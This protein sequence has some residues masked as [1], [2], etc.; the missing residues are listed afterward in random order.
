MVLLCNGLGAQVLFDCQGKI[1]AAL[2]GGVIG[3][4]HTFLAC[5]PCDACN[6]SGGRHIFS[7]HLKG[8][9]LGQFKKRRT[10]VYQGIDTI[11]CKQL[12]A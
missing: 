5:H 4:N 10:R 8:S 6:N 1:A 7:V 12:S 9:Q 2:D 11:T 3:Y